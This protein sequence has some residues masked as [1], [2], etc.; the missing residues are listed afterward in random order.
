MF[1]TDALI[2]N[3]PSIKVKEGWTSFRKYLANYKSYAD[4][5][6]TKSYSIVDA[7]TI[8]FIQK[9]FGVKEDKF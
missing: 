8:K 7:E 2:K 9:H 5:P 4:N 3:R 6:N 1:I